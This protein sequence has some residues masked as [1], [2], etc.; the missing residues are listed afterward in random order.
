MLY[1]PYCVLVSDAEVS[2]QGNIVGITVAAFTVREY[3][4]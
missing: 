1:C 3:V 2:S 4:G